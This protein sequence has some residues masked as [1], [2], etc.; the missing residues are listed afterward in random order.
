VALQQHAE[1]IDRG[2]RVEQHGKYRL[3]REPGG[4]E[5]HE[6]TPGVLLVRQVARGQHEPDGDHA[7]GRN[8]VRDQ[9]AM[10]HDRTDARE[11]EG[12]QQ[13]EQ[14]VARTGD[15]SKQND[16]KRRMHGFL[17]PIGRA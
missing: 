16:G 7:Q 5:A 1:A 17:S 3:A 8:P 10:A 12:H 14:A 9:L 15:D 13:Q 11:M 2:E 4:L 6:G